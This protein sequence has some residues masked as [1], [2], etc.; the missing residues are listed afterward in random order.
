MC[1]ELICD[2]IETVGI[3]LSIEG[4]LVPNA[5]FRMMK[6][7][8]RLRR[9]IVFGIFVSSC[10]LTVWRSRHLDISSHRHVTRKGLAPLMARENVHARMYAGPAGMR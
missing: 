2:T 7:L 8:V 1:T 3:L 5:D 6:G 9:V 4:H 10:Y